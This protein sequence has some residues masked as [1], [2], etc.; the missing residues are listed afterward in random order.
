MAIEI[1]GFCDERFLPLKHA[2]AA[3]FADGNELGAT[4]AVEERGKPVVDIWAGHADLERTRAWSRD[5]IVN[6]ASCTK[7]TLVLSMMIL[8]DRGLIDLDQRV[9]HYWPEFAQGG[10]DT[11]T[12][13]QALTH[14]GGAPGFKIPVSAAMA[15]DWPAVTA[16]LAAE[17]HWFTGKDQICYHMM[18]YGYLVGEIVRRVDGR[19]PAQFFREEIAGKVGADFQVGL[20][21]PGELERMAQLRI[22]PNSF[23]G[24]GAFSLLESIA[25]PET[26]DWTWI[27][28]ED[29]GGCGYGNA[30][31]LARMATILGNGGVAGQ[32]R[33]LTPEA[34]AEICREQVYD[35]CPYLGWIKAGLGVGL[36]SAEYRAPSP[37][38]VHWG[39]FG[40]SWYLADPACGVGVGYAPNNWIVPDADLTQMDFEY[41]PRHVRLWGAL[42]DV[43]ANLKV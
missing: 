5:T 32:V 11:V 6:V 17:P 18:T 16:R 15:C 3:N 30:R 39:G 20:A 37:T 40:G 27:S 10:K 2:F 8:V 1:H 25:I 23:A 9:A 26:F 12:V 4:L 28:R 42:G 34:I 29:P 7:V 35:Q 31:S 21:S 22:P 14:R 38:S 33:V 24:D 36:D 43:L 13:R 19:G 41:D